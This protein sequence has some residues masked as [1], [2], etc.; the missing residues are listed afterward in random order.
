MGIVNFGAP[1]D[2][3]GKLREAFRVST[4]VETGTYLGGT[5]AWASEHFERVF[6]IEGSPDFRRQAQER[7]ADKKN[8]EFLLGDS[9]SMLR[10]VVSRLG[11]TPA[12]F[13]L[14]AHWMPGSFGETHECPLLEEIAAIHQSTAE[15]YILIDDARLFLMPPPSPHRASDWPDIV[16]TLSALNAP[17][18][19]PNY[20]VVHN[21]VIISIP[22]FAKEAMQ[23]F[24]QE[25]TTMALHTPNQPPASSGRRILGSVKRRLQRYLGG[26]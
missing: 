26:A 12:I 1:R 13:W 15:H 10:E 24:Y 22:A 25:Q 3:I 23:R 5:A 17:D 7:H 14:D 9:R 2:I 19:A 8:I 18:R 20:S 4:F 21:D 6:T 11:N 16:S